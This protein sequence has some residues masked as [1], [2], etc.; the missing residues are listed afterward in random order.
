M[1]ERS[2]SSPSKERAKRRS[3]ATVC[4]RLAKILRLAIAKCRMGD[5]PQPFVP[6][7]KANGQCCAFPHGVW[8]CRSHRAKQI[9]RDN[10]NFWPHQIRLATKPPATAIHFCGRQILVQPPLAARHKIE[11][12]YRIGDIAIFKGF[13]EF[14]HH[15]SQ[16]PPCRTNNG[17]A[18]QVFLISRQRPG[19]SPHHACRRDERPGPQLS[20]ATNGRFA[21]AAANGRAAKKLAVTV[22]NERSRKVKKAFW[23]QGLR[24]GQ[25]R[26]NWR[27]VFFKRKQACPGGVCM[28][29]DLLGA[30][31]RC[32]ATLSADLQPSK[33]SSP[34]R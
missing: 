1:S 4:L 20:A 14:L 31:P 25:S 7:R 27:R 12:L 10:D 30:R 5:A 13:S 34:P 9:V 15:L 32:S 6:G 8:I 17:P 22:A 2:S 29:F 23:H 18:L 24:I 33:S 21:V 16:P 11:V 26:G 19:F 3:L 28:K